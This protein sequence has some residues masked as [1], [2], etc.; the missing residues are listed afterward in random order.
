MVCA[1]SVAV[2]T[3]D[4]EAA[5]TFSLEG[6][7]PWVKR[8]QIAG[9]TLSLTLSKA[10][11]ETY[12]NNVENR[13]SWT[14]VLSV[15]PGSCSEDPLKINLD[16]ASTGVRD[17]SIGGEPYTVQVG[18]HD[19]KGKGESSRNGWGVMVGTWRVIAANV[20]VKL[21]NRRL[22]QEEA[23][24]AEAARRVAERDVFNCLKV[25]S[26][27]V[28]DRVGS[29]TW[30]NGDGRLN[31]GERVLLKVPVVN[32]GQGPSPA[33]QAVIAT[34]HP[35][36]KI[37]ARQVEIDSL[38]P[39]ATKD[40]EAFVE[41]V[42]G[43]RGPPDLPIALKLSGPYGERLLPVPLRLGS[44]IWRWILGA[45]GSLLV[46]ALL[47]FGA[48]R[49]RRF[50]A[51]KPKRPRL[52]RIPPGGTV[53]DAAGD[54][55]GILIA[56][57]YEIIRELGRGGMGIVYEATDTT[58]GKSVA[59]K[60]MRE[61]LS[62]SAR[63]RERFLAEARTV[64]KL[65]HPC[66]VDIYQILEEG[67]AVHLVFE[68]VEG[69]TVEKMLDARGKL[70]WAEAVR[71]A[72]SV[73]DA[74]ACAHGQKIVHRD[75]K[76]SNVMVAKGGY[77]K[78]MDFGIARVVK[79][80]VSRISGKDSSGTLAYMA[81]EQELG[82]GDHR[83]DIFALGA[84][85]YEMLTGLP[86]FRGPNFLAQKRERAF[87]PLREVAPD[88]PEWLEAAVNRCLEP[89]PEKRHEAAAQLRELLERHSGQ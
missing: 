49:L 51:A 23:R 74:L 17:F 37:E 70:P 30:G 35:Q 4:Y 1:S 31:P 20:T 34:D 38:E 66:I 18:L 86:P 54:E 40:V 84:T 65:R 42:A 64:A 55:K 25:R 24:R 89:D 9:K 19:V 48:I 29:R 13:S 60:K 47:V 87:R 58:L 43:Y 63:E 10:F 2:A 52:E 67:G 26:V 76:P 22:A 7:G 41:L 44:N 88:A 6:S 50:R 81:P 45:L 82:S 59:V 32:R 79:D 75:L 16:Q 53:L 69:E 14:D 28:E 56:G 78:V 83:V 46:L 68:Y 85:L 80:T 72:E 73:C 33:T 5:L 3:A 11:T 27:E 57:K 62:L 21:T 12:W 15:S 36:I 8:I 39:G 71:I 77:V 61:E